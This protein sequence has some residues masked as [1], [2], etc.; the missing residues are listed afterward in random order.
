MTKILYVGGF[1]LP[2]KGAAAIRV[3]NNAKLFRAAG[4]EVH[5]LGV[6]KKSNQNTIKGSYDGFEYQTVQYPDSFKRWFWYLMRFSS[7]RIIDDIKPDVVILYDFPGFAILKWREYCSR[8]GIKVIGDVTEWYL[9]SGN[10]I[11]KILRWIDISVRMRFSHHKLDGMITISKYLF[12]YYNKKPRFLL[13]PLMDKNAFMINNELPQTLTLVYAGTGGIRKDR[14]DCVIDAINLM[15]NPNIR[16]KIVGIKESQYKE[17]FQKNFEDKW[18]CVVFKGRLEHDAAVEEIRSSH[19]QIFVRPVNRVTTAGFPSKLVESF[20][21]GVPVIT[22]KTSNISDFVVSGVNGFLLES[23]NPEEIKTQ[24]GEI[25][26]LDNE[27]LLEIRGNCKNDTS[28]DYH[29]YIEGLKNFI[30]ITKEC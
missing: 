29:S 18:N 3:M 24:L 9:P 12:N 21:L 17:M 7:L 22:N 26:K 6:H 4:Y 30:N 2:D 28:F 20:S 11:Q 23:Y 8:K 13:P 27:R 10:F 16:F 19:F 1:E 14:L 5:M 25:L 15:D